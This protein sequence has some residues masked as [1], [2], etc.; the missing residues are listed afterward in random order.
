MTDTQLKIAILA[1]F[2]QLH[3][4]ASAE[5]A[6]PWF[7]RWEVAR[8]IGALN[9]LNPARVNAIKQLVRDGRLLERQKPGDG[10]SFPQYQLV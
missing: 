2:Q 6:E 8:Q 1:A 10:R 3:K 5:N 4:T 7:A 9:G